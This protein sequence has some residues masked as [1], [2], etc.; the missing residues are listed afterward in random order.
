MSAPVHPA[1]A[2]WLL[3]EPVYAVAFLQPESRTAFEAAGLDNGWR[4]Y[5]AARSAPLGA[6]DAPP[7][8]AA[9]FSF[10]PQMVEQALP[11][12]WT[13]ASPAQV[14]AA[15]EAGAAGALARL[16]EPVEPERVEAAAIALEAVAARLDCAGRVLAAAN[17]ALPQAADRHGRL[18]QAANLLREHRGDGH[19]AALVAAG[20]DGC[21]APVLHCAVHADRA[22]LQPM[23]GWSDR[24]WDAAAARLVERGWLTAQGAV[25]DL[26]RTRH[27]AIEAATD[28]AAGRPWEAL[29]DAELA[30]LEADLRPIAAIC[31]E[32][33]PIN[34]LAMPPVER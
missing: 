3:F 33:M 25:T 5:F 26:G 7:V 10:A 28:R 16:L 17:A 21:E 14:L 15:R 20:L 27:G 9:F 6:V 24:E 29:S 22:V 31:R 2:L 34:P 13:H 12:A 1:R 32:R 23:R 11:Q 30:R 8:V 19:V 18:W 4:G